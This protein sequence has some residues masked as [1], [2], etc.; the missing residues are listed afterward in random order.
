MT[1]NGWSNYETWNVS[2]WLNNEPVTYED[3]RDLLERNSD[4][5]AA[6]EAI[7]SYVEEMMPDLGASM[8][9]DLL[10]AALCEVDWQEIAKSNRNEVAE[11]A[12]A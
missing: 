1:Y 9:A 5:Y 8:A 4:D 7:K 2:L 6:G 3:L 12:E 10:G 11:E